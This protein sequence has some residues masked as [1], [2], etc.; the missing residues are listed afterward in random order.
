MLLQTIPR[1]ISTLKTPASSCIH[2][3]PWSS[4][5]NEVLY[6]SFNKLFFPR[7][8]LSSSLASRAGFSSTC[9][10]MAFSTPLA[11]E[12]ISLSSLSASRKSSGFSI[13][14]HSSLSLFV[15]GLVTFNFFVVG[16]SLLA[17][18]VAAARRDE[19]WVSSKPDE[20][21]GAVAGVETVLSLSETEERSDWVGGKYF[22]APCQ[23]LSALYSKYRFDSL[24]EEY[25]YGINAL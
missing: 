6:Q 3:E 8:P 7:L 23:P 17:E 9:S 22:L 20:D 21:E 19:A 11:V 2:Y 14:C 18:L 25:T 24:Y 13:V 10:G 12:A 1:L 5:D 4:D 15:S 16:C